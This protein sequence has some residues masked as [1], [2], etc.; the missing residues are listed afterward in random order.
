MNKINQ[1][2]FTLLEVMIALSIFAVL[3]A[4][5]INASSQSIDSIVYLEDKTLASWVAENKLTQLRLS[6]NLSVKETQEQV[7]MANRNWQV[8]TN[9]A[10][11]PLPAVYRVTIK[12][13]QQDQ[14]GSLISLIGVLSKQ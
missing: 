10:K 8:S 4:T 13:A 5:I 7:K 12:V 11:T 6:D 3:A 1:S 9:M 14:E 2:G